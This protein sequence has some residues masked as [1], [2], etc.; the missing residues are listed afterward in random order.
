ML[1]RIEA[2]FGATI[3]EEIGGLLTN[4]RSQLE[5]NFGDLRTHL[6]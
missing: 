1:P 5:E 6:H 4:M 3:A 2:S